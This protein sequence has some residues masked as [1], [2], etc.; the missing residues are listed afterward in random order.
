MSFKSDVKITYAPH[1]VIQPIYTGGEVSIGDYHILAT[2]LGEEAILTDIGTGDLLARVEGDG[3]ALTTLKVTASASHLVT[4]SRSLLLRIYSLEIS[5]GA[6]KTVTPRLLRSLKPHSTPVIS[7]AIDQTGTLL[8][9]GAADGTIKVWDIIGGY[10]THTFFGHGG[11]I[12]ALHFFQYRI[13]ELRPKSSHKRGEPNSQPSRNQSQDDNPSITYHLASGSEDGKIRIWDLAK[14]K[15]IAILESHVSVVRSLDFCSDDDILLSASRDK[16]VILWDSQT[17]KTKR[18]MP[19]LET[20]ECAGFLQNGSTIYTGGENG[21]LRVWRTWTGAELTRPQD[22]R[23][24]ANGI[25][26]VLNCHSPESLICVYNDQSLIIHDLTPLTENL[27]AVLIEPLPILRRISGT[28]D[29]LIDLAYVSPQRNLLALA[30][31]SESIRLI[32]TRTSTNVATADTLTDS[33]TMLEYFGADVGLL[34]GHEDIIICMDVDWSGC[35]LVTGAKDNTAKIWKIDQEHR[36]YTCR[37]TFTG[38]AESLGAITLPKSIPSPAS[39]A[40]ADPI[41]HPPAF[42]ITGSQDKTVKKWSTAP[43]NTATEL[44]IPIQ[45]ATFTRKAHDKDINALS[46]NHSATLFASASQDRTAKIWSV[47]DGQVQGI[48]RG[49]RRGVWS[50]A[51]APKDVGSVAGEEGPARSARGLVLTGSG[52]KTIKIWSLT[53]FSCIRTLEGHTNSI[54]KV[55]WIPPPLAFNESAEDSEQPRNGGELMKRPTLIASAGGDGLVKVWNAST[56]E[57]VS[58]LDNHT[59]R[60]WSLARHPETNMLISGGADA[61]ITFWADTTTST[62]ASKVA[63]STARVEQEQEL[64]NHI[65]NKNYREAITLALALNHPARLLSLFTNVVNI[66]PHEAGSLT[67]IKAVDHVL[68]SLGDEQFFQLLLRLRDWNTSARTA[69]IAQKVLYALVR[70]YPAEKLSRL[71]SRGGTRNEAGVGKSLADVFDGLRAYTERH[72]KRIEE[73]VS[74]SYILDFTLREMEEIAGENLDD[75][76]NRSIAK[77]AI[78]LQNGHTDDAIV[79]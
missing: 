69:V 59:D 22:A 19:I 38:H 57:C 67:G 74:E 27:D 70:L 8:A 72:Y 68:G 11:L 18:V 21:V 55:L 64:S 30:T 75:D 77:R 25:L 9:T 26:Q 23:G 14:R 31:N 63:A 36:Q 51:F 10:V 6:L 5:D 79:V 71:S 58:T 43:L 60:V 1:H 13:T 4:C 52:D 39:A 48:L 24:E 32:S 34:E 15:T 37:A 42:L 47:E 41:N 61:V 12:S 49:H 16:T 62:L 53:D 2:C 33:P 76:A 28:H 35:W 66:R 29:E 65:K 7:T 44:D 45:R 56:G 73:L 40:F 17:W 78:P 20:V 50:I 3:E 46:M 54:L